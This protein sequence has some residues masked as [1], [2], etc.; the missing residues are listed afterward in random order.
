MSVT[1]AKVAMAIKQAEQ[2][3]DYSPRHGALC[4]WCGKRTRVTVT[5]PWDESTRTRWHRCG[6]KR[7]LLAKAGKAIKSVEVEVNQ[8]SSNN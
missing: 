7:C 2:G 3:V 5:K 6:N 4:P 8:K 1:Q